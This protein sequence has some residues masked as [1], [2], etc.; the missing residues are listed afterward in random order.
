MNLYLISHAFFQMIFLD[1]LVS[2]F[3][4]L[5]NLEVFRVWMAEKDTSSYNKKVLVSQWGGGGA[6]PPGGGVA[7]CSSTRGCAPGPA[8]YPHTPPLSPYIPGPPRLAAV[9]SHVRADTR[10]VELYAQNCIKK[11]MQIRRT[12]LRPRC[13]ID[14]CSLY[15]YI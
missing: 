6:N 7:P 8:P 2:I 14:Y 9:A 15:S 12:S 4:D 5:K 1:F 3:I 10:Y 13:I 11:R